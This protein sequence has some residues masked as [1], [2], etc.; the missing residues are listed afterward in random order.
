[1]SHDLQIIHEHIKLLTTRKLEGSEWIEIAYSHNNS[2]NIS[3]AKWTR[4]PYHLQELKELGSYDLYIGNSLRKGEE[5]MTGSEARASESDVG[6][7]LIQ[8]FD[9]EN[10]EE[11][12]ATRER[13]ESIPKEKVQEYIN[14]FLSRISPIYQGKPLYTGYTG[15]GGE[16]GIRLS[17]ELGREEQK[18]FGEAL[19]LILGKHGA[20]IEKNTKTGRIINSIGADS[21]KFDVPALQRLIGS[22]NHERNVQTCFL[23]INRD[24]DPL[25]VNK[26]FELAEEIRAEKDKETLE[27]RFNSP[28]SEEWTEFIKEL[29]SRI[30]LSQ[31][32]L[33]LGW[34]GEDKEK[35][36]AFHCRL[37][38]TDDKRPSFIVW[39]DIGAA[40]DYHTGNG[41]DAI[42]LIQK[43]KDLSFK[44]AVKFL[45]D[46]VGMSLPKNNPHRSKHKS[47]D[48]DDPK[49]N[50]S[51]WGGNFRET[52]QNF[53][54]SQ[55]D[56]YQKRC[57][58]LG[59]I[60]EQAKKFLH[61]TSDTKYALRIALSSVV[62]NFFEDDPLW[63]LIVAPPSSAKTEIVQSLSNSPFAWNISSITSKTLA[64]GERNNPQASLL[65]RIGAFGFLFLKDVTTILEL[66]P[67]E[68]GEIFSQLREIYD[69]SYFKT[70]GNGVVIN[71][72]GKIGIVGACTPIIEK[73]GEAFKVLGERFLM[74]RI[75]DVTTDNEEFALDKALSDQSNSINSVRDSLKILVAEFL[76]KRLHTTLN[77]K[78]TFDKEHLEIVK[79]CAKFI[80]KSRA[81]IVRDSYHRDDIL[82]K[83]F[84]EAPMRVAKQL[85]G[86]LKGMCI[87]DGITTPSSLHIHYLLKLT[88]DNV[89]SL[90]KEILEAIPEESIF[91]TDL[92]RKLGYYEKSQH[93]WRLI[94]DLSKLGI[95]IKQKDEKSNRVSLFRSDVVKQFYALF[96]KFRSESI[97]EFDESPEN[98]PPSDNKHENKPHD[99]TDNHFE[100]IPD[101]RDSELW[102]E[103]A[104]GFLDEA[105]ES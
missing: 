33:A 12:K 55:E 68:R 6:S 59:S 60:L 54:S 24:S 80:A 61:I 72:K 15:G 25:D 103:E 83:P 30:I 32:L 29:K 23:E 78:I 66:N 47:G 93:F 26:V 4:T 86:L 84:Q 104:E 62:A 28:Y 49:S 19:K 35:Y 52:L 57:I 82:V 90:K 36:W 87:V 14:T 98:Y 27:K 39:D 2:R 85:K 73:Y 89:P 51:A 10:E 31:I 34:T 40:K 3:Q 45:A 42:S 94:E 67:M 43:I 9:I 17:R 8:I 18:P 102:D 50:D 69:G 75:C 38:Q 74:C 96:A 48:K 101:D 58:A 100:D 13:G 7:R 20:L 92:A 88:L 64:S 46:Q 70:F 95:V 22:Y 91:A 21:S 5:K 63:M 1:M 81:V 76:L 16:V 37:C 56:K 44:E 99:D 71:W 105:G 53:L 77:Q 97:E 65:K 79:I 11:H 41:Y